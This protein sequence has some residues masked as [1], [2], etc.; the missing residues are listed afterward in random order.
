MERIA[1]QPAMEMPRNWNWMSSQR[2]MGRPM[3]EFSM[4]SAEPPPE[5]AVELQPVMPG[6]MPASTP[7]W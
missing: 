5:P 7:A 3:T 1:F 2:I 6:K 4:S